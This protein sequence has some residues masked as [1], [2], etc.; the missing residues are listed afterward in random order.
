MALQ[1]ASS[2]G[3][4]AA[5][6]LFKR[7]SAKPESALKAPDA[8]LSAVAARCQKLVTQRALLAASVSA[9]PIPGLDIVADV[10]LLSKLLARINAEFGLSAED[11]AALQPE[12]RLTAY[13]TI[14]L[15]GNQLIG[16]LITKT[17]VF[18]ALKLVGI[19]ITA[20]Q[21]TKYVP[22][23]GQAVSAGLAYVAMQQV[24]KKHIQDCM[25]VRQRLLLSF[26]P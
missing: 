19:K 12:K 7:A 18:H 17:L 21:A 14:G 10:A 24:C 3:Q 11:I 23:A 8:A 9:V 4:R 2:L 5:D 20:K 25:R 1:F 15:V 26:G 13:K 22:I 6:R 16:Q